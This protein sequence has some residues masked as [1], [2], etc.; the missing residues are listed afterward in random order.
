MLA[1]VIAWLE[2]SGLTGWAG[3]PVYP[4]VN[5]LHLLGLVLLVGGIGVVDLAIL[6]ALP[7]LQA[8]AV[9]RALTPYALAGLALLIATGAL[10]FSA[11]A[12]ALASSTV[13]RTKLLVILLA[14][15]NAV[16]FHRLGRWSRLSA[17]LSL[18]AWLA[19]A[20]LGRWIAYS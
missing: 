17:A 13:F 14:L 15:A 3:G 4:L 6:G 1:A 10:L 5:T 20:A 12:G 19:V 11:D 7:G 18:A 2:A 16:A 8:A 9:R